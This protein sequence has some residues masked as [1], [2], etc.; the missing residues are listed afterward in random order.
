MNE[1]V[2]EILIYI[3]KEMREADDGL[4]ELDVL[5][6]EL[7][8][9]GYTDSEIKS[10]LAWLL[11]RMG[12]TDSNELVR[13]S[14]TLLPGSFRVLHEV[15][16]MI[17]SP[18]AFGYLLQLCELGLIDDMDMERMLER[19]LMLGSSRVKLDD[20]KTLVASSLFHLEAPFDGP[21]N[22]VSHFF[23]IH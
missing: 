17:I 10:A 7:Q 15:E 16:R 9:K 1:R 11:D 2:V 8:Q 4:G 21:N 23:E 18:E 19:A 3:M 13:N 12:E 22:H 14:G 5:S 6:A 20:M